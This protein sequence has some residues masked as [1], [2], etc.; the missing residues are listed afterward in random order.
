MHSTIV[1]HAA[2]TLLALNRVISLLRGRHFAVTSF[3]TGPDESR[4]LARITIV[5][6]TATTPAARVVA[7][8]EKLQDVKTVRIAEP[9]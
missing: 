7:C 2:D 4:G 8:L 9:V 1:V 3:A 6:D 5:V